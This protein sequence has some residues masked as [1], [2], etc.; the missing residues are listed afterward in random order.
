M[1]KRKRTVTV[2]RTRSRSR[3]RATSKRLK[4]DLRPTGIRKKPSKR[5]TGTKLSKLT[6]EQI[7]RMY[8]GPVTESKRKRMIT[9]K[10]NKSVQAHEK[11]KH[12]IKAIIERTAEVASVA[13]G[14]V[15][16][17]AGIGELAAMG[18]AGAEG[19]NAAIQGVA[20]AAG[21]I[22]ENDVAGTLLSPVEETIDFI[23]MSMEER[24]AEG[25]PAASET[26]N[27]SPAAVAR[28]TAKVKRPRIGKKELKSLFEHSPG[29]RVALTP[30][31]VPR[32]FDV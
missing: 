25:L 14:G 13:A 10:F 9:Q 26:Y 4:G 27:R 11:H 6:H 2:R 18:A 22:S 30:R 7:R 15:A 16:L 32:T 21:W 24:A 12:H 1:V 8:Y 3:P 23:P 17:A 29:K 20:R 19:V 31:R 5:P 28:Q